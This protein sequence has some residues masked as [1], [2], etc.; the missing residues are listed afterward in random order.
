MSYP[1]Q[2]VNPNFLNTNRFK[3]ILQRAP[4]LVYYAQEANLPG[5][6]IGTAPQSTPFVDIYRPGDKLR[7]EEFRMTFPVDEDMLNYKEIAQW[8][9]GLSFPKEFGQYLDLKNGSGTVSDV[10][11]MI[12]DSNYN[13]SHTV[14]FRDAFPISL[15]EIQFNTTSDRPVQ[16]QVTAVFKY[17]YY[18]L[19]QDVNQD[20]TSITQADSLN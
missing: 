10:T 6:G 19:D 17:T 7:Y 4:N 14:N 9:V 8:L 18:E 5:M 16:A 3:V 20:S 2:P 15:S 13:L 12:L 1:K 11:L